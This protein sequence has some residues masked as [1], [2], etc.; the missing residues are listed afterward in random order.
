[1]YVAT[2][3]DD[4][5]HER[6]QNKAGASSE[7]QLLCTVAYYSVAYT[8]WREVLV[9]AAFGWAVL[10]CLCMWPPVLTLMP[11]EETEQGWRIK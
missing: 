9:A 6:R 2:C 10:L 4:K 3:V 11:R 7:L 1:V 5:C 8:L